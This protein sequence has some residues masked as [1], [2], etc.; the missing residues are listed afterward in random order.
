MDKTIIKKIQFLI[1]DDIRI[2]EK[3]L[4]FLLSYHY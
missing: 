2:K 3:G 1:I 4:K